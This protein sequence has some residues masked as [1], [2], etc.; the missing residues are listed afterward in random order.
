MTEDDVLLADEPLVKVDALHA[1]RHIGLL[2]CIGKGTHGPNL[3]A[4]GSKR[5]IARPQQHVISFNP[6]YV[7]AYIGPVDLALLS[8]EWAWLPIVPMQGRDSEG[9]GPSA[10]L[11]K[12]ED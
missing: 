5:T 9:S 4:A 8:A 6:Q 12:Q 1:L 11:W 7:A 3:D 2:D 10:G